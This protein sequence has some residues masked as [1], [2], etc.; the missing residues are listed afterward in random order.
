MAILRE[1]GSAAGEFPEGTPV[2]D[3]Q[4]TI[5]KALLDR[6]KVDKACTFGLA[7]DQQAEVAMLMGATAVDFHFLQRR[8]QNMEVRA[9]LG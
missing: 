3:A 8:A 4:R 1:E 9:M 5:P 2:R 6:G 7:Q